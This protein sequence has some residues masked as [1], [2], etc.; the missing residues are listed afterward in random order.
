MNQ[1]VRRARQLDCW[2]PFGIAHS[3]QTL[4][5]SG[6]LTVINNLTL[7]GYQPVSDVER[8][9]EWRALEMNKALQDKYKPKRS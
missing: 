1:R 6:W 4:N 9:P 2:F 8:L 7:Y 3:F 5:L